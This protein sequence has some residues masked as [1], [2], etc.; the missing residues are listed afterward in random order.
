MYTRLSPLFWVQYITRSVI[1]RS[2]EN[3]MLN[4]LGMVI[5]FPTA[6]ASFYIPTRN[7]KS[8]STSPC[9]CHYWLFSLVV[10]F[11]IK[12]LLMK[13]FIW[14][15]KVMSHWVLVCISLISNDVQNLFHAFIDHL[16]IFFGEIS[17]QVHCPFLNRICFCYWVANVC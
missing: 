13:V 2:Y 12:A 4:I 10:L 16:Y 8:I 5:L 9:L 7:V 14:R 15:H 11:V 1:K 17:I 6:A 3:S